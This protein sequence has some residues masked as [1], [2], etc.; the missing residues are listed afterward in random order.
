VAEGR[1]EVLTQMTRIPLPL[2]GAH[3][4]K[5]PRVV[6]ID[7]GTTNSLVAYMRHGEPVVIPGP[8]GDALLPSIVA[9]L[10]DRTLVGKEAREQL[11]TH[12][13]RTVYSVKRLMGKGLADAQYERDHL[14]YELSQDHHEVVRIKIG[15]RLYTPPEV[16]AHILRS[17][18]ERAEARL[19]EEITQAVI[20]VPAY[21]NDSQR[22]ATRDAG[23]IAGLEVL[24][25]VNEPT[26]ACLAYGLDKRRDGLMAVY[27]LGGGT[28]DISILKLKEGIFEVQS[29]H[30]DTHLGGDDMDRA[31]AEMLEHELLADHPETGIS[32]QELGERLRIAAE[33]AKR[34]LT[35]AEATSVRVELPAGEWTRPLSREAFE[36]IIQPIVERTLEPCR[37]ALKDADVTP[38]GI[39]EVV[40]VGGSTRVPLVRRA[41]AELFGKDPKCE[42]DPDEVVALGAGVQ[43]GILS[44]QVEGLLLLD[45][46]P[47]SLGLETYGGA[48]EKLIPRNSTIPTSAHQMFT[49]GVDNQTAIDIHVVQGER[50]LA[51]DNRSLARFQVAI[52][53]MPAGWP[54]MEVTFLVDENG[55]LSVAA[56][57]HRSEAEAQVEVR[58]SYGLNDDEVERMVL[59]SFEHAEKDFRTRRIVEAQVE[60]NQV[61]LATEKQLPLAEQF[62]LEGSLRADE[63][64]RIRQVLDDLRASVGESDASLIR[65]RLDELE[66]A[67]RNLVELVMNRAAREV[68]KGQ[69]LEEAAAGVAGAVRLHVEQGTE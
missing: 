12:P 51:E 63:L 23:R 38:A 61:I 53:P 33:Q 25:I 55:I 48:V 7:L 5:E 21:F 56:Y 15:D 17:L 4:H 66:H 60:A 28:F 13:E 40:L 9:F 68:L 31:L 8:D 36:L 67:A 49:T 16:S 69:S 27:D 19:G 24:R 18:K 34:D 26:A 10:P 59:E 32:P 65:Q 58:P 30:G 64:S 14:P 3:Q 41:V 54:R 29:T 37:R 50:E 42:L 6:G 11:F 35:D 1:G 44:G 43:A 46:N 22:Q 52:P 20:T 39:D 62:V 47:L 2:A 57:E 45:V